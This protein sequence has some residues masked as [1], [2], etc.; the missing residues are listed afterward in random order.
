[1]GRIAAVAVLIGLGACGSTPALD[2]GPRPTGVTVATHLQYY[3]VDAATLGEIRSTMRAMGPRVR[4]R[5]WSAA[6]RWRYRWTY[7]TDARGIACRPD[8]VR[9][10]LELTI[11]YPRWNP[12]ASPDSALVNWWYAF[13]AGLAE[14]E[15]GH[16]QLA[17]RVAGELV[18]AIR[19]VSA[20]TCAMLGEKVGL[21]GQRVVTDGNRRQQ[22]Y[23]A[24]TRNGATQI[25]QALRLHEP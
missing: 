17:L 21:A 4:G 5:A 12:T 13:N 3:D 25:Q 19:D 18:N 11:T 20:V 16:G 6:T 9:V 10:H 7:G 8:N 23:D 15:R 14:H 1:M 2:L 22:D 24:A